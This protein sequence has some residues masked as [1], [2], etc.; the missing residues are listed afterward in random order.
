MGSGASARSVGGSPRRWGRWIAAVPA[1]VVLYVVVTA[2]QVVLAGRQHNDGPADAIVV[3]GAAQYDGTPSGALRGRLDHAASLFEAGMAPRIVVT[4][5]N[6]PGD[7]TTEGMAGYVYLREL[8][9][10]EDALLVENTS[11]NTWEQLSATG[12]ILE[13]AGLER[14][15]LVSDPY[16]NLRLRG[17]ASEVGLDAVVSPA[18][19]QTQVGD[20][21]RET[22]AVGLGRVVG[23]RRI[24]QL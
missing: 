1:L 10:P 2:V 3:M 19:S 18:R 5:G 12:L 6:Q 7:R 16:H 14:V 17:T 8:G 13:E 9:V 4:G 20:V 11:S 15:V 22:V 21:A 23:Y 24:S